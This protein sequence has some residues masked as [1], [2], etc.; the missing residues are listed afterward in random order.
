MEELRVPLDVHGFS[1]RECPRCKAHFK[2][3]WNEREAGVLAA[4]LSRRVQHLNPT[5][6]APSRPRF[7]P[8]CACEAPADE[9]FTPEVQ[10]HLDAAARRLDAEVRW[11][12]VR[13][14]L[15]WMRANPRVT[16]APAA[17]AQPPPIPLADHAD[18]LLRIA[19]P[20]CGEEHKV[21]DAW[22]GPVRCHLCGIAHLRAGPRDIGLELAMLRQWAGEP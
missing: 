11:R 2:L 12:R 7:C 9:F 21:S 6:A 22:L 10:R 19:L 14:P 17:A 13:L 4:A 3:R 20:C 5:D 18:D 15:E 1:R 16:S 8:Y